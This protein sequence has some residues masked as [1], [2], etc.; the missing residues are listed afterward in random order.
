MRGGFFYPG[1]LSAQGRQ[2]KPDSLG[3]RKQ[4]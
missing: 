4:G 3:K 1:R 2:H